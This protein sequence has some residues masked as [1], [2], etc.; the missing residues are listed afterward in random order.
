MHQVVVV[1]MVSEMV[2][3]V[4]GLRTAARRRRV[5]PVAGWVVLGRRVVQ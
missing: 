2:Q 4:H 3:R 1:V 5:V